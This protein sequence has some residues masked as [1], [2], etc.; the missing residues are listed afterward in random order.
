MS[1]KHVYLTWGALEKIW[2]NSGLLG[3]R[4]P[5]K[6]LQ[7]SLHSRTFKMPEN[8][9]KSLLVLEKESTLR[10]HQKALKIS[11]ESP[12]RR[13]FNRPQKFILKIY[14]YWAWGDLKYIWGGGRVENFLKKIWGDLE[15]FSKNSNPKC[16]KKPQKKNILKN[17]PPSYLSAEGE[18][19][20]LSIWKYLCQKAFPHHLIHGIVY[21]WK[22]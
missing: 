9:L 21:H 7:K 22:K 2:K 13:T 17:P 8:F 15:N 18:P 4:R 10:D 16:F 1:L 6:F 14:T 11:L 3:R 19:L 5:C 20:H 12:S